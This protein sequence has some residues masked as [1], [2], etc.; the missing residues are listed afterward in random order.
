[1]QFLTAMAVLA[2]EEGDS[3]SNTSLVLPETSELIAGIVAFAIV[4]FFMWRWAMPTITKTLEQRRQAITG[5]IEEAEKSKREAE[6]LLADYRAQL[7]AAKS[8]GNR[9]IEEARQSADQMKA[10]I[11]SKAEKDAE[12]IRAKAR[13]EAA[14]EMSRAL[15]DAK[16]QVGDISVE[17]A[18]KIVGES[19]DA[20]T[21]R[22][23]I[24][25]YLADLEKL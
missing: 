9:V 11:L 18:G 2:A 22:A 13:E 8:E 3:A 23:L 6:G 1:M 21:H 25:R 4:F 10:D 20:D 7:D 24:D 12:G 16:A 19:L 5:Q 14:T 15:A 17:L